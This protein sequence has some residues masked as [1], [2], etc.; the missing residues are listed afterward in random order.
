MKDLSRWVKPKKLCILITIITFTTIGLTLFGLSYGSVGYNEYALKQNNIT[1]DIQPEVYEEGLYFIGFWNSFM[2]FPSTYITVEFTPSYDADD[3][4]ISVQTKNGLLIEIDISFQ[5]RLR[6]AELISLYSNYGKDYKSYIQ[7]V[8]RSALRE[9]VGN[10][11]A[12][13]LYANRSSV[14]GSMSDALYNSLSTI[15]EIGDFQLRSID[16]PNSFE[17]AVEE[18]EVWRIEAEIAQLKQEAEKIKQETLNLIAEY[19]ANRTIIE[20]QGLADALDLMRQTF[21]MTNDELLT[22]LWI[23][24]IE[25][26]DESYLFIGLQDF[27]IVIPIE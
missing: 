16:F 8:A 6:K 15:V 22:Y 4:P 13:A 14:I 24:V 2:K 7:A 19:T 18:Y 23:Q 1:G 26:H 21:N 20:Y 25:E 3:I 5:F 10:I 27:P 17:R 11:N 9:V 12:E